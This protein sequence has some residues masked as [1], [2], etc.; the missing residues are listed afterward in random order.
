M[1]ESR[2]PST[3]PSLKI[4]HGSS[5]TGADLPPELFD[6]ILLFFDH[7]SHHHVIHRLDGCAHMCSTGAVYLKRSKHSHPIE[8]IFDN[9]RQ[10]SLVSLY[11]ANRCRRYIF[12]QATLEISSR[13]DAHVF[14]TYVTQ[15]CPS[16]IPI[17]KLISG[18]LVKQTYHHTSLSFCHAFHL[19]PYMKDNLKYSSLDL[20]GP[21]PDQFSRFFL[22]SPHWGFP[23]SVVDSALRLFYTVRMIHIHLP[24]F[25]H[26]TRYL[27]HFKHAERLELVDLTWDEDR[28]VTP[29][30]FPK[31]NEQTS[32][33]N[34]ALSVYADRCTDNFRICLQVA[35]SHPKSI[36]RKL[37]SEVCQQVIS[38]MILYEESCSAATLS[39][40]YCRIDECEFGNYFL[41][42][43]MWTQHSP[44]GHP[45]AV[46]NYPRTRA[47]T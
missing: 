15:G 17:H 43:M 34:G 20:I 11:W 8:D 35:T 10:C 27:R 44:S 29:P 22:D 40:S 28:L 23:S 16:L 4:K 9:L 19:W 1:V 36:L 24:S 37:S 14:T 41:L 42:L 5:T 45:W 31:T 12:S 18:I 7:Y 30:R 47:E 3:I 21:I 6:N 46:R 13:E 33:Q 32:Q 2:P 39:I 26:V 25:S 38:L